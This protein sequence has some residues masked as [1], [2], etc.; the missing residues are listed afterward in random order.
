MPLVETPT[1][2]F[3]GGRAA[4]RRTTWIW[5][6]TLVFCAL[7]AAAAIVALAWLKS[8]AP[9][10]AGSTYN[11]WPTERTIPAEDDSLAGAVS[12]EVRVL[13]FQP[14]GTFRVGFSVR[15]TGRLAVDVKG[16]VPTDSSWVGPMRLDRLEVDTNPHAVAHGPED[17]APARDVRLE[18][19]T[20]RFFVGVG[21]FQGT[22]KRPV[23]VDANGTSV[24]ELSGAAL[25]Y[26]Y[27]GAFHRTQ[28]VEFQRPVAVACAGQRGFSPGL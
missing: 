11:S 16:L 24:D 17:T 7:A 27:A 8:Y 26:A 1:G 13:R 12:Q 19:G 9:L 23:A 15:N 10:T 22:C 2:A 5:V 25:R 28:W 21:S 4:R 6:G 20:E 18:P 14:G 3:A